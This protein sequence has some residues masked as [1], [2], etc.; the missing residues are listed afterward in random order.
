[1]RP[2]QNFPF[3]SIPSAALLGPKSVTH[4]SGTFCYLCLR[5]D[6]PANLIFSGSERI[7]PFSAF[8]DAAIVESR[9]REQNCPRFSRFSP[10]PGR[11]VR[12]FKQLRNNREEKPCTNVEV[13]CF[14]VFQEH[15]ITVPRTIPIA[16]SQRIL[17]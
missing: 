11:A 8:S 1:V 3:H 16:I 9:S 10:K 2:S 13:K 15:L 12:F 5:P 4:V 7:G 6:T 17:R 14:A